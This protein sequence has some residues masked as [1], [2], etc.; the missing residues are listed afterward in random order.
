MSLLQS[1]GDPAVLVGIAIGPI[2]AKLMTA[3]MSE[4]LRWSGLVVDAAEGD[5]TIGGFLV[6]SP[7]AAAYALRCTARWWLGQSGWRDDFDRALAMTRD[8]DPMS[9]AAIGLHRLTGTRSHAAS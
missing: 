9:K 6:N 1:I 2:A 4:V 8:A 5:Q 3:D 7:L